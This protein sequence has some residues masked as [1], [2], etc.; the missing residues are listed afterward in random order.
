MLKGFPEKKKIDTVDDCRKN[1]LIDLCT[2]ACN[3]LL[4][5]KD[6]EIAELKK[7]NNSLADAVV[8]H[9]GSITSG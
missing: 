8:R 3:K 5:E 2:T 4:D 1:Y 6:K 7:A 9:G